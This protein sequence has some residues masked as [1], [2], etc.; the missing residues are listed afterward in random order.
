MRLWCHLNGNMVCARHQI[1]ISMCSTFFLCVLTLD[2]HHHYPPFSCKNANGQKNYYENGLLVRDVINCITNSYHHRRLE[3]AVP[4][5]KPRPP[6]PDEPTDNKSGPRDILNDISW[7]I[8]TFFFLIYVSFIITNYNHRRQ[9][10]NV[11]PF[12]EEPTDHTGPEIRI[13]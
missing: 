4:S 13:H 8:G 12:P 6:F 7:V 5:T 3:T 2:P 9:L 1:S 11:A 10:I